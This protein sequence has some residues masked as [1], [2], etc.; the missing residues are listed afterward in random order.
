MDPRQGQGSKKTHFKHGKKCEQIFEVAKDTGSGVNGRQGE[1][2]RESQVGW[3]GRQCKD[4]WGLSNQGNGLGLSHVREAIIGFET[5]VRHD[6]MYLFH[7]I[8]LLWRKRSG[9][10]QEQRLAGK[11]FIGWIV[12][13]IDFLL[14][15][16]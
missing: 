10:K 9:R 14:H 4:Q 5:K 7:K 3:R 1:R 12:Y 15:V 6:P 2:A 13:F 11:L 16:K 8:T